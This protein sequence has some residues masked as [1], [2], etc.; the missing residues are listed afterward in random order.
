M[1]HSDRLSEVELSDT[2][3]IEARLAVTPAQQCQTMRSWNAGGTHISAFC[4]PVLP[5]CNYACR[6]SVSKDTWRAPV[7]S[8]TPIGAADALIRSYELDHGLQRSD[9]LAP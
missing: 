1:G 7:E 3:Q 9:Q 4:Y 6:P 2:Y 5:F 8:E